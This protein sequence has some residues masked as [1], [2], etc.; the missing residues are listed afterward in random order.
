MKFEGG[1][2]EQPVFLIGLTTSSWTSKKN[3]TNKQ[4]K[5]K[6]II[7]EKKN[8]KEMKIVI[9]NHRKIQLT[10]LNRTAVYDK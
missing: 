7:K 8:N 1:Q 2:N 4:N 6:K 10:I 3:E 9:N 5:E